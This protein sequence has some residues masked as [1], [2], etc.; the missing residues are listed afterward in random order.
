MSFPQYYSAIFF[1]WIIIFAYLFTSDQFYVSSSPY[2]KLHSR[3]SNG[4][5]MGNL[6]ITDTVTHS[7]A[8]LA[9]ISKIKDHAHI[10]T[11]LVPNS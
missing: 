9:K 5:Y 11:H 10:A 1:F 6:I 3:L 4:H 7:L 2:L 8:A